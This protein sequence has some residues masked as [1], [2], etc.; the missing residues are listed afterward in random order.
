SVTLGAAGMHWA[1]GPIGLV[2]S[3]VLPVLL[4]I[5]K[6]RYCW[7]FGRLIPA[8]LPALVNE[9]TKVGPSSTS[10][11]LSVKTSI[12]QV[13][14]QAPGWAIEPDRILPLSAR[15]L[16]LAPAIGAFPPASS[17]I[18][19]SPLLLVVVWLIVL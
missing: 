6:I 5:V 8:K 13:P 15:P 4:V 1:N 11:L 18:P 14:P 10:G 7:Q 3:E 9:V 12:V 17:L 16:R 19:L 2:N